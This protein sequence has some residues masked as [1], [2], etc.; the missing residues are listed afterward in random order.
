MELTKQLY[1]DVFPNYFTDEEIEEFKEEVEDEKPAAA[2]EWLI[3][4]FGAIKVIYSFQ[5]L[6]GVDNEENWAIVGEL[7]ALVW[8]KTEGILQADNEGFSNEDGYHI[9]WQFSDDVSGPW[10]MAVLDNGQWIKFQMDIGN[11]KQRKEFLNG[12]VPDGVKRI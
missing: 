10:H 9:L 3:E 6:S 11:K 4:Y 12:K 8:N 2:A 1:S 7:K 5:I